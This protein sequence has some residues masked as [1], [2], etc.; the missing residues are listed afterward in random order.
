VAI[1]EFEDFLASL[2]G[3]HGTGS[4]DGI[5]KDITI[6]NYSTNVIT[7]LRSL[8]TGDDQIRQI[9]LSEIVNFATLDD[10]IQSPI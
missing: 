6:K 8:H 1:G 5:L 9:R 2:E 4:K 3:L 10:F 7:M